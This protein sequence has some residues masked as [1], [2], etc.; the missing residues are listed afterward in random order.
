MSLKK[1]IC[2]LLSAIILCLTLFSISPVLAQNKFAVSPPKLEYVIEPGQSITQ[3][4]KVANTGK[5]TIDVFT[6]AESYS[7]DR[8]GTHSFLG[9]EKTGSS[10]VD[11]IHTDIKEFRLK[12]NQIQNVNVTV[13]APKDLKLRSY[14][15]I[16]FFEQKVKG[17]KPENFGIQ[18]NSRIGATIL[19]QIGKDG[20]NRQGF[21]GDLKI[22]VDWGKLIEFKP[23]FKF[24][25]KYIFI[26][27]EVKATTLFVN[28]GNV[29]ITL[30]NGHTVFEPSWF[31]KSDSIKLFRISSLP[32]SERT[33][34]AI[35]EKPPFFGPAK[36][37]T[38]VLFNSKTNIPKLTENFWIIP[39]RLIIIIIVALLIIFRKQ[40]WKLIKKIRKKWKDYRETKKAKSKT[41]RIIDLNKKIFSKKE[42]APKKQIKVQDLH[43]KSKSKPKRPRRFIQN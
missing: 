18:T 24:N 2:Y 12:P 10:A 30:D 23:K 38:D 5:E 37:T 15:A 4:L 41:R 3:T 27:K 34:E 29:F 26:P 42:E 36:A 22:D 33:L 21:L 9:E 25:W 6:Y 35:W 13:N 14:E 19:I 20:I 16:L 28:N 11:W 31:G 32:N 39:W 17:E 43:Q 8:E 7:I 40:I 1:T